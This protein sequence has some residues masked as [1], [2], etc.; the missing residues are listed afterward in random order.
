MT[1]CFVNTWKGSDRL[2]RLL[3][4]FIVF[5]ILLTPVGARAGGGSS[6]GGG[7]GGSSHTSSHR[8]RRSSGNGS[9]IAGVIGIGACMGMIVY[10]KRKKARHMHQEIKDDLS[11]AYQQD[12]F[13]NEKVLK[14][15][16]KE[17]YLIIQEA[18]SKQDLET[19]KKHLSESL[20]EQWKL[21]I[22]WQQYQQQYN[23]LDHIQL[24]KVILV[25]LHDAIDN[26]QD[27]FWVYIEGKM[28]DLMIEKQEVIAS[29]HECFVEYWKFVRHGNDFL[30]DEIKQQDEVES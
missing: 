11:F 4:V 15:K 24:L 27:F 6:S 20:Y 23:Q 29:N 7:G 22:E 12:D 25:D 1:F 10:W 14:K 19:L 8:S 26:Q 3:L 30:L 21:K 9:P 18:W 13:W 28:N 5:M 17:K 16:V 2:K